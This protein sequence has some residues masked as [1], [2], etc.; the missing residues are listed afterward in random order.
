V[1]DRE[2]LARA[3]AL[4]YGDRWQRQLA[5]ALGPHHPDGP[6]LAIDDRLVRRWAAG[7]RPIPG[8]VADALRGLLALRGLEIQE[9]LDAPL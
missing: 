4:L 3:G 5:E 6:R 1:T 8:W 7:H 2:V 9:A